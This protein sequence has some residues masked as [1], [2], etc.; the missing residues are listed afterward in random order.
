[1]EVLL[2]RFDKHACAWLGNVSWSHADGHAK[3]NGT[4]F[5][6]ERRIRHADN[7][8]RAIVGENN[9]GDATILPIPCF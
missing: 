7:L 5:S 8:I 6:D 1:M 3:E 2:G 9:G 4:T